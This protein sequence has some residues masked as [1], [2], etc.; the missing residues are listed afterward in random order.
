MKF[1]ISGGAGFIG[2]NFIRFLYE[3]LESFEIVCIDKLTYAGSLDN[4][5][6]FINKSNFRFLEVDISNNK[7]LFELLGNEFFDYIVNFAAESHVDRSISDP[8]VFFQSNVVGVLN[9]LELSKNNGV[10]RFHQ[11]STDEV[12]GDLPIYGKYTSFTEDSPLRPSSPYSASKASADLL[13]LAYN[14]TYGLDITISRCSNNYGPFQI[15][16]KLIPLVINKILS[17]QSIPIYGKG[18]NIRDWIYVM[19]H[20]SAI[21]AILTNGISGEIYNIGAS[22]EISNLSIVKILLEKMNGSNNLISFVEDRLGHD[23]RYSINS[24]KIKNLGWDVSTDF[25][26]G[27]EL[28]IQWYLNNREWT[29]KSQSRL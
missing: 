5:S 14:R 1:L 19:D 23:R 6:T 7:M 9:L 3:E 28:T 2:S 22:Y 24:K 15:T 12:Y 4:I 25:A 27:I 20:C 8:F 13:C 17:N 18:D 11:V 10:S 16:E 21:Y 29:L 26:D